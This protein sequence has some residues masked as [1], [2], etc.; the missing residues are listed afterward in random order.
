MKTGL[1]MISMMFLF[2]FN[3]FVQESPQEKEDSY[4]AQS[5]S[6]IVPAGRGD[7]IV[8]NGIF[9]KGEW[10]DALKIPMSGRF[11]IYLVVDSGTLFIGMKSAEPLGMVVSEIYI[12]SKENEFYNLHSSRTLGEG[13]IPF[14]QP[15]KFTVN[16]H[17]DWEANFCEYDKVNYDKWVAEGKPLDDF[18]RYDAIFEKTDGREYRISLNKFTG[19]NLKMVVGLIYTEGA[20]KKNVRFPADADHENRDSWVELILPSSTESEAI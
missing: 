7:Q 20:L 13:V 12:T 6:I 15:P 16:Y 2:C 19:T 10:D 3:S 4:S 8:I 5:K 11:D 17:E 18:E 9:S 14:G 1:I